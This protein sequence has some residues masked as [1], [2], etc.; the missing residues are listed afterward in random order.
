MCLLAGTMMPH[1]AIDI[2][3]APEAWVEGG[4][5]ATP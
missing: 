4:T 3:G 2:V 1:I 5:K